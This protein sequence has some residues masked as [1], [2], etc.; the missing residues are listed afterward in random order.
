MAALCASLWGRRFIAVS[1]SAG[2]VQGDQLHADLHPCML[3]Q[4]GVGGMSRGLSC[5]SGLP[6]DVVEIRM[7]QCNQNPARLR[8]ACSWEPASLLLY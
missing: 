5:L 2:G 7:L 3:V 4:L 6:V 1:A 8:C